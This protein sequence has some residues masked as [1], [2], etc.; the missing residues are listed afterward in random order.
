MSAPLQ[1]RI[2]PQALWLRVPFSPAA[3]LWKNGYQ[4]LHDPEKFCYRGRGSDCKTANVQT[5]FKTPD[6]S[7]QIPLNLWTVNQTPC[8]QLQVIAITILKPPGQA[9]VWLAPFYDN[10]RLHRCWQRHDD[11][12]NMPGRGPPWKKR[13]PCMWRLLEVSL[14]LH[15][16]YKFKRIPWQN[17]AGASCHWERMAL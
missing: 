14:P 11:H 9:L 15:H 1:D 6:L 5:M 4:G 13:F 3:T 17:G 2:L 10:R 16:I 7:T 8:Q 12:G